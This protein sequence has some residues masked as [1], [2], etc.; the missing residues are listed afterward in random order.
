MHTRSEI[1]ILSA[2]K[3]PE[4]LINYQKWLISDVSSYR[5]S[6]AGGIDGK[7]IVLEGRMS[8]GGCLPRVRR[9]TSDPSR[10]MLRALT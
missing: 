8:A 3:P 1:Y 6:C 9:A 5:V 2:W 7:G 4:Y 10:P